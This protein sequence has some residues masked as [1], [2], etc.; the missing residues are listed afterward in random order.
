MGSA[1]R[2]LDPKERTMRHESVW[3]AH[4][5]IP[6]FPPLPDDDAGYPEQSP[7]SPDAD[8]FRPSLQA[9]VVVI[10]AGIT[11]L[12][13]ALLAQR[14]GARTIVL[15]A[16]T[17]GH[18]TSGR[19]TGKV[20]SQHGLIYADLVARHG[21]E[22]AQMYAD[23][24]QAGLEQL[25]MLADRIEGGCS[26][27]RAP[28]FVY[29]RL[30][31][32]AAAIETEA[33]QAAALGLP[34][35]L[36]SGAGTGLPFPVLAALRFDNQAHIHPGR[37][38]AGLAAEFVAAGGQIFEH[39]RVT[40]VD[41][42]GDH[43]EIT[44]RSSHLR[45]DRCVMATLLPIGLVAGCFART[46]PT[47]SYGLAATL[48]AGASAQGPATD[49]AQTAAAAPP[50]MTISA[51]EDGYSTRPWPDGGPGGIIVVGEGHPVGADVDTAERY[52]SL[53]RWARRTFPVQSIDFRWSAHDYATSDLIPY[54]GPAPMQQRILVATGF[55]K[56]GLTNG[57]AAALMIADMLAGRPNP[58]APAF[59]VG[60][61][62]DVRAVI[63][64]AKANLHS[65]IEL[66][67]GRFTDAPTCTHLGCALRWNAAEASWDCSCHGSRF[68]ESGEVLEGPAVRPLDLA[69]RGDG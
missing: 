23:A 13:T 69:G 17:V 64:A 39:T 61:L 43:V 31:D 20:T 14:D 49:A 45:A 56:W 52:A 28:A 34:A 5:D 26:L 21:R 7:T 42:R 36:D 12:T 33:E 10:G 2:V 9:D 57:T 67:K 47:R 48:A 37:Y 15:E 29:T 1:G 55:A 4:A 40:D 62:G 25:V 19:T 53:E 32:R 8:R 44:A 6:R 3:L 16:R 63:A 58:W 50:A 24:N 38:L 27:T 11:G 54:V 51:D 22:H 65:G 59:D 46:T 66:I 30:A 60:R 35:Q 18:G 41:D 68:D